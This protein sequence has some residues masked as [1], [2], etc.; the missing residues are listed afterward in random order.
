MTRGPVRIALAIL[1]WV[2][3]IAASLSGTNTSTAYLMSEEFM[4]D[5]GEASVNV[6]AHEKGNVLISHT[7]RAVQ[8]GLQGRVVATSSALTLNDFVAPTRQES[9]VAYR[10]DP[11]LPLVQ[12]SSYTEPFLG[13]PEVDYTIYVPT[14]S[15]VDI[16][17]RSV[18][19]IGAT[20]SG[21]SANQAH[22]TGSI[23]K[24]GF[25]AEVADLVI[26]GGSSEGTAYL[27][28]AYV[29]IR[30]FQAGDLT[31]HSSA[32]AEIM[33]IQ[34][35]DMRAGHVV[36]EATDKPTL[37]LTLSDVDFVSLSVGHSGPVVYSAIVRT[38]IGQINDNTAVGLIGR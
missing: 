37:N 23:L 26:R 38:R 14:G 9:P 8:Q 31:L 33:E 12:I 19:V 3:S 34:M 27:E 11:W 22:A 21:L 24:D 16:R 10:V 32:A 28:A 25:V 20:L 36:I 6:I 4:L 5:F 35:L 1:L 13:L 29:A 17:A 15:T 18:T 30:D 7:Q 2:L